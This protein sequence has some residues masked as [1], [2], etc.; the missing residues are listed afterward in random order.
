MSIQ[1][2]AT[3]T[4]SQSL[5]VPVSGTR[6]APT[7]C[8]ALA[9]NSIK[10]ALD[11]VLALVLLIPGVLL[12]AVIAL[13]VK[14]S[15]PGPIV[16]RHQRVGRG[17]RA[18][19]VLKFRSM[20]ADAQ[21]RLANDPELHAMYLANNCK[22]PPH[23]DPRITPIGRFLRSSSLDEL[24]QLFNVLFGTMSIVGPRPIVPAETAVY[25]SAYPAYTAVRPGMT[26]LWQ[27]SGRSNTDY[28]GR[29]L[30]DRYYA[31]HWSPGLDTR[32]FL[33]TAGAVLRSHG[34]G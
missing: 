24:P 23:L 5:L 28:D 19:R 8:S 12:M 16:F 4:A 17:G 31:E 6:T 34:A 27:V 33:R 21:E 20:Y 26:G 13:V 22:V 1:R 14:L 25:G 3:V 7:V 18:I 10:R 30:L 15:S 9:R 11:V 32:I 2:I 29:V